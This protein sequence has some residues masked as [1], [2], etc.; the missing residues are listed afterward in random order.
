MPYEL[1]FTR[2]VPVADRKRY[3]NDCCIGGDVVLDALLPALRA[4]YEDVV[5]DQEDWGWFAW[6]GKGKVRLAVEI[7]CNNPETGDYQVLLSSSVSR[8]LVGSRPQDTPELEE[9][10]EVVKTALRRWVGSEVAV[11]RLDNKFNLIETAP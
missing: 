9:L 11:S 4:R 5:A 3:I 10:C 2:L 1:S 6:A 8:F 7:S